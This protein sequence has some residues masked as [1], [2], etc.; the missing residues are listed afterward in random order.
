MSSQQG[1]FIP[2]MVLISFY[3]FYSSIV[4]P[5]SNH[6]FAQVQD[7]EILFGKWTTL[8]VEFKLHVRSYSPFV[9]DANQSWMYAMFLALY[10]GKLLRTNP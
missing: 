10:S 8:A 2:L 7:I 5:L 4:C 6:H 9:D 1:Q 3:R